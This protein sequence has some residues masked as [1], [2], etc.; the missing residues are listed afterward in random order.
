MKLWK[1][2][3]QNTAQ[4]KISGQEHCEREIICK[5]CEISLLAK[6]VVCVCVCVTVIETEDRCCSGL[7]FRARLVERRE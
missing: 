1:P 3:K 4:M 6:G 7:I 2:A 5:S